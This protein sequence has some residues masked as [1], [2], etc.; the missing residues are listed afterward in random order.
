MQRQFLQEKSLNRSADNAEKYLNVDLS[1]KSRLIPYS[2]AA[3]M[4]GLND[5]Y[6]EE[7]INNLRLGILSFHM[8]ESEISNI[9]AGMIFSIII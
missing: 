1:A 8:K 2:T 7:R 6:I 5:L 9:I 4:L 3:G